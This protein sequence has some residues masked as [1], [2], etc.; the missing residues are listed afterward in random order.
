MEKLILLALDG[1]SWNLIEEMIANNKLKNFKA[2]ID[3]GVKAKLI[4]DS[5]LSSPMIFCS[6]FTGKNYKKHGIKDFYSK[7]EDLKSEQIWDI[8]HNMGKRI[9]IYRPLS[10]WT[11]KKIN[12]FF[13]PSPFSQKISAFPP[14]LIFISE[15]DN[16]ART[17]RYSLLFLFRF[18][19]KLVKFRFPIKALIEIM[20]RSMLLFFKKGLQARMHL[21]KELELIIHMN[22]Y[23]KL[24]YR[25]N[26]EFSVFF[27][28]SCD[29][30][31]HI[32]WRDHSLESKY[33]DVLPKIYLKIDKFLGK[34]NKFAQNNNYSIM[35]CSDHGFERTNKKYRQD[36]RT[37]NILYLLRELNLYYDIYGIYMTE[38]VV[39][40]VRPDSKLSLSSFKELIEMITCEG[41][42][43]FTIK[44]YEKKLVVRYIDH[45]G[46]N[47]QLKIILPNGKKLPLDA[48]IDFNPAHTGI[49]SEKYGVFLFKGPKIKKGKNIKDITPF[50]ITPTILSLFNQPIPP[51]ID[52]RILSEILIKE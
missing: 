7:E 46:D 5:T 9:G 42:E 11:A 23:T 33:L 37:I 8:L 25:Y 4:A 49:H 1:L 3:K 52:G 16:K 6:M 36:F 45:F 41:K 28:Y 20:K 29:T 19:I 44:E 17:E 39:F 27:D 24:L 40:R 38:K 34:I 50:D 35:I 31:G 43:I 51:D 10:T 48:I 13:I 2:I 15:L 21:I 32:Y 12:G 22:L 18:F 47:R 26:P 14:E 30:L